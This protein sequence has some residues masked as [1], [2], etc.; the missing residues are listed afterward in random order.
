MARVRFDVRK[1]YPDDSPSLIIGL[2]A[3]WA[4]RSGGP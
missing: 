1:E 4:A 2:E 3:L